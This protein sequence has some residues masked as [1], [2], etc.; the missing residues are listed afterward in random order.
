MKLRTNPFLLA[1]A[2]GLLLPGHLTKGADGAFST[3]ALGA[4]D[5]DANVG[6]STGRTYLN[7]ININGGALTIN[8]VAFQAS[9]GANPSG[10]NFSI[11]GVPNT[12]GAGGL[13]NVTG[14]P[15]SLVTDFIHNGHPG[16]PTPHGPTPR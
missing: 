2:A 4:G 12:F 14:Q 13:N 11:S 6:L 7:A 5:N 10:T 3:A 1:T 9:S 16:V 15:G 8:G